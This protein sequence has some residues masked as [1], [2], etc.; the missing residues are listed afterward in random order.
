MAAP[1][2]ENAASLPY[3]EFGTGNLQLPE[4]FNVTDVIEPYMLMDDDRHALPAFTNAAARGCFRS[5]CK[6]PQ[7]DLLIKDLIM[8][9][10]D[11]AGE[12][13]QLGRDIN[14]HTVEATRS[15]IAPLHEFLEPPLDVDV[16]R[17][18]HYGE[19]ERHR[20]DIFTSSQNRNHNKPLLLFVHGGGFIAG[21]KHTA[22]SPFYD[23]IAIWAVRNGFNAVNMT[24]RLAPDFQWPSGIQDIRAAIELIKHKGFEFGIGTA[25]L[26]LMG[27]SAGAA[28]AAAYA[29]HPELYAPH[30]H[31]LKGLILLSGLY[32]FTSMQIGPLERSYLGDDA[33]LY[34]PRSSLAGL[35]ASNI[36]M[37]LTL[38]ELDPPLFEQQTLELVSALQ[39]KHQHPPQLVRMMGHNHLSVALY[40]GLDDDMFAPQLRNFIHEKSDDKFQELIRYKQ[41]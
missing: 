6:P 19:H 12:L 41:T 40:L 27:Q 5:Q 26:F 32:N 18:V 36:P 9:F 37:L 39:Q 35:V 15:L 30:P 11:L 21:D 31:E 28:H 22:G 38:A 23:N 7:T 10:L 16:I 3:F 20:L 29:A 17:D 8:K 25:K 4:W 2:I 1:S 33:G 34:S 13:R 14:P 24:Y